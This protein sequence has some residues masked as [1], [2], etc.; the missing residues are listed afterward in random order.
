[1]PKRLYLFNYLYGLLCIEK[2][3]HFIELRIMQVY[4]F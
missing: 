3:A 2:D 4:L 1:M